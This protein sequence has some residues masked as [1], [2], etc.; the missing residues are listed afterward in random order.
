M[1][2]R[3]IG[4]A[5]LFGPWLVDSSQGA[6][7]ATDSVRVTQVALEALVSDEVDPAPIPDPDGGGDGP[8]GI[9]PDDGITICGEE[10]PVAWWEIE[11]YETSPATVHRFAKVP[12][13]IGDPKE[14]RVD[15]MGIVR[16]A[17][18]NVLSEIQGSTVSPVFFDTDRVLRDLED[19]DS[20]VGSRATA[21]VSSERLLRLGQPAWRV[22]DGKITDTE[23]QPGLKFGLQVRDFLAVLVDQFSKRV[24]PSRLFNLDDFPLMD[25]PESDEF[26]P[27]N[28]TK[29]GQPVGVGYGMLTDENAAS[30]PNPIGVVPFTFTQRRVL[31]VSGFT[32]DEYVAY[33]HAPAP[34]DWALFIPEG[35]GLSVGTDFPSR[36]RITAA[37]G[38]AEYIFPGT[39]RWE[40]EFGPTAPNYRDFNGRRYTVCYAFGPRSDLNRT[41]RVPLVGNIPGIE[42]V[43]NGTGDVITD[44]F[45]QVLHALVNWFLPD[46]PYQSG[47][48]L[49]VPTVGDGAELYSR[50]DVPSFRAVQTYSASLMGGSPST[51]FQGAWIMGGEAPTYTLQTFLETVLKNSRAKAGIDRHGRLFLSMLD[52][53]AALTRS[54]SDVTDVIEKSFKARRRRDLVRNVVKSRYQRRY[55]APLSRATPA[56]SV[57]LHPQNTESTTDWIID[58][59]RSPAEGVSTPSI[60]KY[61]EQIEDIS[62]ELVR[63]EA[64]HDAIV[65][66]VLDEQGQG[67]A[68]LVNE[69]KEGPCGTLIDLGD[70]IELDHF[71]G[72]TAT[73]YTNRSMQCQMHALNMDEWTVQMEHRDLEGIGGSP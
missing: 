54:V 48:W 51:G 61:G 36:I 42:D 32:V 19:S 44:L 55:A 22:Y 20:L 15:V 39:T 68:P 37:S 34:G 13:N 53:D 70:R 52:P 64:T 33:A 14:P 16:R 71:E 66:L 49:N 23:P 56:E 11:T 26:F 57:V 3:T 31:P 5:G 18:S 2:R 12:I 50:L 45:E 28:P 65:D 47:T 25:N 67:Q 24:Y 35:P 73:G 21:Y 38:Y 46:T 43:G 17:L 9:E 29:V 41:G 59:Q 69:F 58:N 30:P 7:P 62:L 27:G 72:V 6:A 1:A 10:V 4:N 8:N 40:F 63:D 60:A